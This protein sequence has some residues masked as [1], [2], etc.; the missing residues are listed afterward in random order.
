MNVCVVIVYLRVQSLMKRQNLL[1]GVTRHFSC[2]ENQTVSRVSDYW[3]FVSDLRPLIPFSPPRWRWKW[4]VTSS[5]RQSRLF[6]LFLHFYFILLY[7]TLC[8]HT[9]KAHKTHKIMQR[10]DQRG[11]NTSNVS[12]RDSE[13][14]GNTRDGM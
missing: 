5:V 10:P 8:T 2:F 12:R 7:L 13:A 1:K 11:Q 3:L 9:L 6:E 4:T 14:E